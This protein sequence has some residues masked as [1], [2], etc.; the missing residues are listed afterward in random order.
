MV[1]ALLNNQTLR[2]I[3]QTAR[4]QRKT[5]VLQNIETYSSTVYK[6]KN[7]SVHTEPR[8]RIPQASQDEGLLEW[9]NFA[10]LTPPECPFSLKTRSQNGFKFQ[11]PSMSRYG[12]RNFGARI[13]KMNKSFPPTFLKGKSYSEILTLLACYY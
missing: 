10:H 3:S 12:S 13:F 6:C 2:I 4:S 5:L 9:Q 1:P 7:C 11:V 8:I